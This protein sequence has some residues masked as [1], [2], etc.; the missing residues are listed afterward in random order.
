MHDI[1]HA[2]DL[3]PSAQRSNLPHFRMAPSKHPELQWHI[4]EIMDK[5]Q[6]KSPCVVLTLL[7]PKKNGSWR[8]FID[9]RAIKKVTVKYHLPI[10]RLDDLLYSL[11]GGI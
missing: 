8:M 4:K 7:T 9:S 3:V 10:L 2:I 1:Q 6:S 11:H 5:G